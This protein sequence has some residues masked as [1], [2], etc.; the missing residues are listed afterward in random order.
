MDDDYYDIL[1]INKDA[2]NEE[3]I[4]QWRKL[5]RSHH[6]DKQK[7]QKKRDECDEFIKKL[8]EAKEVLIDPVKRKIYNNLGKKGLTDPPTFDDF[9]SVDDV[10]SDIVSS[11]K[12][13][14]PVKVDV[15]LTLEEIYTGK[16][17]EVEINRLKPCETCDSEGSIDGLR[18]I[19]PDCHGNGHTLKIR[20]VRGRV[21]QVESE[22][23]ECRGRG[24]TI[25]L[26]KICRDCMGK[27]ACNEKIIIERD[28]EK[29]VENGETII[30]PNMGHKMPKQR[31]RGDVIIV[32][33]QVDHKT[34]KRGL[35]VNK[36]VNHSHLLIEIKISLVESLC[37]FSR[38]IEH[39]D[40]RKLLITETDVIRPGH[41][42]MIRDEGL[43]AKKS[44]YRKGNLFVKFDVDYPPK[45]TD[46]QKGKI[47]KA[48]TGKNY[49]NPICN[50]KGDTK[51]AYLVDPVGD[52]SENIYESENEK[53]ERSP[54]GC[55][56]Q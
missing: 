16:K 42:K 27:G 54:P 24:E 22:C 30:V 4:K 12:L 13:A 17:V 52:I 46:V 21:M 49:T 37:G 56:Q 34:F 40:G 25:D 5:S 45:F 33:N 51:M 6:P 18:Q 36:K 44:L 23:Y 9:D 32:I 19:C 53:D 48:F 7:T 31:Y 29:G 55:A 38:E 26:T 11:K 1:G 50:L 10:I 15:K 28:I 3:I 14:P 43:P 41:I 47:C 8:N 35:S 2:T 20:K 39:L